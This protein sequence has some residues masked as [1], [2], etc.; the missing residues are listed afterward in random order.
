MG[1]IKTYFQ[2]TYEELV[3]KV[4]WPTWQEVQNSAV[5]VMIAAFIIA[6]VVFVMD[7]SLKSVMEFI[8]GL[9]K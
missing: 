1:K 2:E 4:S 8:Y 5:I 9:F 3:N 7:F 6:V